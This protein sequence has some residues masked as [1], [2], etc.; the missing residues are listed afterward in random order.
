MSNSRVQ[1]QRWLIGGRIKINI[2]PLPPHI[3]SR[4]TH[5][6]LLFLH[7]PKANICA[8]RGCA[9]NIF[10]TGRVQYERGNE[11]YCSTTVC[12]SYGASARILVT[13][14]PIGPS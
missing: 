5:Q 4:L 12:P 13:A 1:R 3:Q 9:V 10:A 2:L 6:L 11:L 14:Y 7:R 8:T